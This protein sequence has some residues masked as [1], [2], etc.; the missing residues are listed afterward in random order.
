MRLPRIRLGPMYWPPSERS[1]K[2]LWQLTEDFRAGKAHDP[3]PID[4][5]TVEGTDMS[6][7]WEPIWV[8]QAD[9][10]KE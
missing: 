2:A 4:I 8:G 1:L 10:K 9:I 3:R 5:R 7:I 6:A